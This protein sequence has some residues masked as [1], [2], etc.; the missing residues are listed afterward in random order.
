MHLRLV[1]STAEPITDD[2]I[3]FEALG[4]AVSLEAAFA[5]K[6]RA[7]FLAH[8]EAVA[9]AEQQRAVAQGG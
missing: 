2:A 8:I 7:M 1:S 4:L 6:A 9:L 5:L 3:D